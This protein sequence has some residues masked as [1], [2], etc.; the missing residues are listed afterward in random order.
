MADGRGEGGSGSALRRY[1]DNLWSLPANLRRSILRH[2]TAETRRAHTVIF[3]ADGCT[4]SAFRHPS[5]DRPG[6]PVGAAIE[7]E[8]TPIAWPRPDG[9]PPPAPRPPRQPL[10]GWPASAAEKRQKENS[11]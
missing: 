9:D 6:I 3:F 8:L 4:R 7:S 5:V 1:L 11:A 10:P 2:G